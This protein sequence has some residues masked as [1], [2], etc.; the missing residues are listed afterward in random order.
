MSGNKLPVSVEHKNGYMYRMCLLEGSLK[1]ETRHV[2]TCNYADV[3]IIS[4]INFSGIKISKKSSLLHSFA[5]WKYI[6]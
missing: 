6:T 1:T 2:I 4:R 3:V 5:Y